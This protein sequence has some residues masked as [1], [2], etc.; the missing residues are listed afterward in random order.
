MIADELRRQADH[1]IDLVSLRKEVGRELP[2]RS[3]PLPP[4]VYDSDEGIDDDENY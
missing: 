3:S 2:P 1:F 4:A